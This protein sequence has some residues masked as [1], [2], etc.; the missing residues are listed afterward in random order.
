M[1]TVG[2]YLTIF[3]TISVLCISC[4]MKLKTRAF[5]GGKQHIHVKI[6]EKANRDSPV[7]VDML[8]VYNDKLYEQ[9]IGLT[10]KEWFK[11]KAQITKDYPENTGLDFWSWEWVPGQEIPTQKLPLR[12]DSIGGIIFVWYHSPGAHRL[13]FDPSTDIRILLLE[14][15]FIV[16]HIKSK[17]K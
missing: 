9:L 5:L 12:P 14:D 11:K 16:E 8:Y 4:N 15:D 13:S 17:W 1:K 10:S 6:A 3:V 7:A 2:I